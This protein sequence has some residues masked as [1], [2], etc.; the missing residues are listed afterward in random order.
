[1][2]GKGDLGQLR[3]IARVSL[4]FAAVGLVVLAGLFSVATSASS[5]YPGAIAGLSATR[6]DLPLLFSIGCVV[7][8]TGTAL[9]TAVVALY[10]S[11]RVAGPLYRFCLDL[12]SGIR[13][14]VV[15]PIRLRSTDL[16]HAEAR[17]MN[18]V[19][20]GLYAYHDELRG[21]ARELAGAIRA[22]GRIEPEHVEKLE[23]L[24]RLAA[25]ART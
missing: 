8:V 1:M 22:R 7:V 17:R 13:T 3:L 14:G 5:E 12:E 11:F 20:A 19:I 25:R 23:A 6:R 24:Q 10:G 21:A 2:S 4:W 9:I 15:P 18:E 16:A